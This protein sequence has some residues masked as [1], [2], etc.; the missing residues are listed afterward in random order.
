[1]GTADLAEFHGKDEAHEFAAAQGDETDPASALRRAAARG[2]PGGTPNHAYRRAVSTRLAAMVRTQRAPDT[3]ALRRADAAH[4]LPTPSATTL[5]STARNGD[6]EWPTG[7]ADR[8]LLQAPT[9]IAVHYA[10]LAW[11]ANEQT[12]VDL[13]LTFGLM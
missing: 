1:L 8:P 6:V 5:E 9:G 11:V 3:V 10:P 2:R 13:R 4:A 12:I 7:P